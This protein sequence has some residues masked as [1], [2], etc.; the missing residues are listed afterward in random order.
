MTATRFPT[1]VKVRAPATGGNSFETN[2]LDTPRKMSFAGS[3]LFG[4]YYIVLKSKHAEKALDFSLSGGW[5]MF[6][7]VCHPKSVYGGRG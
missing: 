6:P 3:L 7:C 1:E 4:Q 5:D 2:R